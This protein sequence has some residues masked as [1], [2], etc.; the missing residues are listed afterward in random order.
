[1]RAVWLARPENEEDDAPDEIVPDGTID[2]LYGLPPLLDSWYPGW[3][4]GSGA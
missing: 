1:M 2:T 3:R 4:N